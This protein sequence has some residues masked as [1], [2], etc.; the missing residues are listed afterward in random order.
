ML[1]IVL[2]HCR[3]IRKS[4]RL[5]TGCLS[6]NQIKEFVAYFNQYTI[7]QHF[8]TECVKMIN[9]ISNVTVALKKLIDYSFYVKIMPQF[10]MIQ[11]SMSQPL[12]LM[13]CGPLK[14]KE[15]V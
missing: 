4:V 3:F 5:C 10:V 14:N 7:R 12:K 2:V 13:P 11:S 1:F 15:R 8:R 6:A 9:N